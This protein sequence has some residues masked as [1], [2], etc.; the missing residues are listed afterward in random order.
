MTKQSIDELLARSAPPT[1]EQELGT[2]TTLRAVVAESR[3]SARAVR[4]PTRTRLWWLAV[5]ILVVP[6]IAFTTSA[7]TDVRQV[8]DFTIPISYTTDTGT[9]VSCSIDLFNGEIDYVETSTAA[10]AF[11]S[12]QDWAGAGQRIYDAA[13]VYESDEAWLNSEMNSDGPGLSAATIQ[14]R[15][16]ISAEKDVIFR[17]IPEDALVSSTGGLGSN[18]DCTGVLH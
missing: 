11:L 13:V 1:R 6:A 15:A 7:G 12:A 4:R 9:E 18:T 14:W 10:V 3:E 8:P 5:P 2:Q 16:W 17:Q